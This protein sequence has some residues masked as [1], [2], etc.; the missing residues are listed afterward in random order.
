MT[1]QY[2]HWLFFGFE[3][4][5]VAKWKSINAP[6]KQHY[7][8]KKLTESQDACQTRQLHVSE[9]GLLRADR[10]L[11]K[12]VQHCVSAWSSGLQ[13]WRMRVDRGIPTLI[14]WPCESELVDSFFEQIQNKCISL[15]FVHGV[16]WIFGWGWGCIWSGVADGLLDLTVV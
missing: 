16:Y 6:L 1:P 8:K 3:R 10:D 4:K 15:A 11:F 2:T 12:D 14:C 9:I 5:I 13:D 7:L